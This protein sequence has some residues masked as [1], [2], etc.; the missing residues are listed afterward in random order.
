MAARISAYLATISGVPCWGWVGGHFLD[1]PLPWC[2]RLPAPV[3]RRLSLAGTVGM[4]L[5]PW[6]SLPDVV[7]SFPGERC[8]PRSGLGSSM[9]LRCSRWGRCPRTLTTRY[10]I[11]ERVFGVPFAPTLRFVPE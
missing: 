1:P 10:G 11:G 8:G 5:L 2:R 9:E 7:A 4:L 3:P 6:R